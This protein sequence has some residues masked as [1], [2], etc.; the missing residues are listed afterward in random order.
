MR[1]ITSADAD[2]LLNWQ[3]VT[4]ALSAGH[5]RAKA[6]LCDQFLRHDADTLLSRAAWIEGIGIGVKS[7]T[8]MGNNQAHDLP[9]V[10]GAMLIFDDKTGTPKALIDS[11]LVTKWKTAGDSVLGAK[12]LANPNPTSLLILGAGTV[13]EN[14]VAAYSAIFPTLQTITIWNRTFEKAEALA[15]KL[16]TPQRPVKAVRELP[17]A[18]AH[19]DII[20]SATMAREPVLFGDWVKPGTHVDLIGAFRADMREADN[21]LLQKSSIYVDS[22]E[23]TIDHIGEL[24]IPM[25]EG[26]IKRRDV[27]ADFYSLVKGTHKRKSKEE[28]T[29]IKNGGGAHL[30]LM[31]ADLILKVTQ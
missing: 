17:E 22:M 2:H 12:L 29:L 16:T 18:C 11:D 10:Q 19:M 20:S 28:I 14:L 3:A 4:E 25:K 24:L 23:T 5:Q 7:V 31:V 30:D 15:Q 1:I 8:V 27:L 9:S 21:S 26:G 13:A 6:K